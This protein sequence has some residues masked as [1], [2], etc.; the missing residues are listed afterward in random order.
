MALSLERYP[1]LEISE[2]GAFGQAHA[3]GGDKRG[4][5]V[6][7]ASCAAI[8]ARQGRR[9]ACRSHDRARLHSARTPFAS[10]KLPQ[11][12]TAILAVTASGH[13][14]EAYATFRH[15]RQMGNRP[16]RKIAASKSPEV[17]FSER[18]SGQTFHPQLRPRA[19]SR[20]EKGRYPDC[21][22]SLARAAQALF[23]DSSKNHGPKRRGESEPDA[24]AAG[25]AQGPRRGKPQAIPPAQVSW[26]CLFALFLRSNYLGDAESALRSV[27]TQFSKRGNLALSVD[28]P[29][30]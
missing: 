23:F 3:A 10:P 9:D 5:G 13:R 15:R 8:L 28:H 16:R 29:T 18:H 12:G 11:S 30:R 19:V 25:G 22:F 27:S 21:S 1:P 17:S 7:P 6:S 4:K 24:K 2:W 20:C 14:L 26:F